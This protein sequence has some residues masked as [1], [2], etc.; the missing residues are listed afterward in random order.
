VRKR[1]V[2]GGTPLL[3]LGERIRELRKARGWSQE[4]LAERCGLHPNY[5]GYIE[6]AERAVNIVVLFQVAAALGVEPA[7]LFEGVRLRDVR[8]LPR[9]RS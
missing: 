8:R 7:A 3:R 4:D 1:E 9:R 5:I 6:R 2:T